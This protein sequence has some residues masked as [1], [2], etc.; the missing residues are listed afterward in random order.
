MG[1]RAKGATSVKLTHAPRIIAVNT[2]RCLAG[3]VQNGD[4]RGTRFSV[5]TT[6]F[7]SGFWPPFW[8][9]PS[10][11]SCFLMVRPAPGLLLLGS[12]GERCVRR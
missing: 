4:L 12:I 6:G 5:L 7:W 11:S 9:P 10:M 1:D 2:V 3:G 8:S